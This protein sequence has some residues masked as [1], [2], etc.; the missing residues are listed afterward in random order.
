MSKFSQTNRT[1]C[2]GNSLVLSDTPIR[3]NSSLKGC[4]HLENVRVLVPAISANS[5][6]VFDV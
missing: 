1:A 2:G 5:D 4:N 3:L 6:F